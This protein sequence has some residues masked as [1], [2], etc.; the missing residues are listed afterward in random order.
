MK[1]FADLVA[2]V[3][4]EFPAFKIVRK[5]ESRLMKAADVFLKVVSFGKMNTF[6]TSFTT[7]LGTTIYVTES[8]DH[9]GD[10][11]KSI[12]LRHERVHMRQARQLTPP[13]FSL[14]YLFAFLPLFLAYFRA[15]FE[16]EAYEETVRAT[17]ELYGPK[18]VFDKSFR[19]RMVKHFTSAEYLWMWPFP[20]TVEK[21]FM[22]A[23]E[24]AAGEIK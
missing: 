16:R 17:C 6:M 15:R 7:T 11:S 19:D 24:K 14:L 3:R 21:W 5:S 8:W 18:A 10:E 4:A 22:D 1:P 9:I 20:K 13:L 2:E 12:T 23:A